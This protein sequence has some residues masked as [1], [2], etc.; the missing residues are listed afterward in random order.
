M[1]FSV[2]AVKTATGLHRLVP[3]FGPSEKGLAE[4]VAA[5][6]GSKAIGDAAQ[7][8]ARMRGFQGKGGE[9]LLLPHDGKQWLFAGLGETEKQ[10]GLGEKTELGRPEFCTAIA[11]GYKELRGAGADR[12]SLYL[13]PGLPWPTETA[14]RW[15]TEA[16]HMAAYSFRAYRTGEDDSPPGGVEIVDGETAAARKGVA[17]G[18]AVGEAIALAR[19]LINHPAGVAHTDFVL[20]QARAAARRAGGTIRVIRGGQLERQGYG[21]IHAV[22]R[23]AEHP[24]ALAALEWGKPGTAGKTGR[25]RPTLALLGKGVVFDTGGLNLKT[26]SG[27]ALMKKDMG[28]AAIVLGAFQAIAALKLPIHLIAVLGLAENAVGPASYHPG[29]ILHSKAGLT[30][31]I[32]NTDAEGRVVLA[33]AMAFARQYKPDYMVDF[34]TLTGAARIALGRDLMGLFCDDPTLL[35]ALRAG[36]EATGDH[37]WPLPLWKPYRKKLDS[38]VAD[39]NNVAGDGMGGAITAA[40]FLK[41]F[42]GDVAWAHLDCYGWSDGENPLFPKGGSGIGV[43]LMVEVAARLSETHPARGRHGGR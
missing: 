6:G 20:E 19:D 41:E 17:A 9:T 25:K 34:A 22:G 16:L 29:D 15:A 31:E 13:P 27:M 21:A 30:I 40:L 28:G 26:A 10:A 11:R 3:C 37:V 18:G 7:G 36:A 42:A 14:A 43:R 39:I 24:P 8:L 1:I 33:D 38:P 4:A 23:A 32:G 12:I 5:A 35:E 2:K